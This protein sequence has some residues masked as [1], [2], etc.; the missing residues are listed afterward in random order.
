[1]LALFGVLFLG[2]LNGLLLAAVG[3]LIML[4]AN[5]SRPPVVVLGRE[6][7]AGHFVNRARYPEAA[8]TPGALVIRSAGAWLYFNADHI[9]RQIFDPLYQAPSGIKTVIIDFSLVPAIDVTAGGVL[10]GMARS[11]K[12][13]GIVVVLAGLRDDVREN[14]T[15]GGAEQDLGPI[16]THCRIEDCLLDGAGTS[17]P[18]KEPRMVNV[19]QDSFPAPSKQ[20]S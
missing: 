11:L 2:L 6:P 14:L 15:V 8:E 18:M 19:P 12:A 5:A 1:L 3:S 20:R 7:A 10:R 16:T 4:I 17:I 13:R 9:R